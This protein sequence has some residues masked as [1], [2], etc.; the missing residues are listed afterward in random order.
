MKNKY[1]ESSGFTIVEVM[2]ATVIFSSILM[3]IAY[4]VT[5][6]TGR[7]YEGINSSTAQSTANN[8]L[9][10]VTQAIQFS[11]T[12]VINGAPNSPNTVLYCIGSDEFSGTLYTKSV[13]G[14]D[15]LIE[16]PIDNTTP[17][18]ACSVQ[19]SP[20]Q[21]SLIGP[22][23][24]L[25]KLSIQYLNNNL[26]SI[27]VEVIYGDSSL[28]CVSNSGY[29][30]TCPIAASTSQLVNPN[31]NLVCNNGPGSQYCYVANLSSTVQMRGQ[32]IL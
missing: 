21:T 4:G 2:I 10:T 8:I 12:G 25:Q 13:S 29:G 17:G 30:S 6:F 1:E 23:M 20:S 28:L 14:S 5:S 7:Y 9:S 22:N 3:L 32:T 18:S 19:S 31:V 15:I 24:R 27:D 11:T 16:T 26:Y